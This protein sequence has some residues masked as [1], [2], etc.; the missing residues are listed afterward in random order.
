M[1]SPTVTAE[2]RWTAAPGTQLHMQRYPTGETTRE[3]RDK[4]G[5]V[6]GNS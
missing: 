5:P 6:V 2:C 3:K 4:K 1:T